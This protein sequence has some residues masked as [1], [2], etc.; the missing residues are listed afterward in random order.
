MAEPDDLFGED[1]ADDS[2]FAEF[3]RLQRAF[4][5]RILAFIEEEDLGDYEAVNLLIF[6]AVQMRAM[7]YGMTTENPSVGGMKLDLDRFRQEFDHIVRDF[8]KSAAELMDQVKEAR[9]NEESPPGG[10]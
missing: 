1:K 10:R 2:G 4:L 9:A 3:E 7:A 6:S 5:E 8:K